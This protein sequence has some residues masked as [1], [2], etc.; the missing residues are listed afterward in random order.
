MDAL[1]ILSPLEF[2]GFQMGADC[3]LARWPKIVEYF[4]HLAEGSG[5]ILLQ[6]IGKTTEGR[7]FIAA[8]ITSEDNMARLEEFRAVQARL[9]DPRGLS[10][11]DAQ[12]L[13][14]KG[15]AIVMISCSIHATEV[16]GT[17]MS[18]ELAY[19]L[20][21]QDDEVTRQILDNVIFLFVPSLNPDGLEMVAGWYEKTLG[22]QF[23]GAQQPFLYH[24]Y[25]GHDN[26]RDWFMLTQVENQLAVEKVH[27]V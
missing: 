10:E 25:V 9:A 15:R 3:K 4:K 16:G 13:V 19:D 1:R 12:T 23:E 8:V 6:E 7:P 18:S 11:D 5:R 26:N 24:K 20:L 2:Y 14:E 21:T 22:T 17:Q 27:N